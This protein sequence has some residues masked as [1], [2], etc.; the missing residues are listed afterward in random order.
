MVRQWRNYPLVVVVLLMAGC[1]WLLLYGLAQGDDAL[2]RRGAL[3]GL[4]L[5]A[6]LVSIIGGRVIP[7][8]PNVAL[9]ERSPLHRGRAW[10]WWCW[11]CRSA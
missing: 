11:C 8:L 9:I 1:E 6:A 10:I 7:F 5:I 3:A 2:Q 4:W